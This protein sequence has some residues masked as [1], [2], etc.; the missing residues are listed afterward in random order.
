MF[1]IIL[2][3]VFTVSLIGLTNFLHAQQET[4]RLSVGGIPSTKDPNLKIELVSEGLQ[5]PSS[6]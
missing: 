3:S 4:P 2:L 5:S 6:V 1:R